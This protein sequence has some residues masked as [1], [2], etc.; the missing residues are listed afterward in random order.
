MTARMIAG[1][2]ASGLITVRNLP[3]ES[4]D[5]TLTLG[6]KTKIKAV[7]KVPLIDPLTSTP[8]QSGVIRPYQ[9]FICLVENDVIIDGGIVTGE[10]YSSTDRKVTWQG[11]GMLTYFGRRFVI[12][13]LSGGETPSDK[14]VTFEDL[15]LQTIMKRVVEQA[16][17]WGVNPPPI[18]FE[19]DVAGSSQKTYQGAD[20]R[21]VSKALQDLSELD[22]GPDFRFRPRIKSTDASKV[23]WVLE[24]GDPELSA[25]VDHVWDLSAIAPSASAIQ[26]DRGGDT[27]ATHGYVTGDNG[28]EKIAVDTTLTAAGYPM[29]EARESRSG[30]SVEATAQSYADAIVASGRFLTEAWRFTAR[31]DSTPKLED[32]RPGDYARLNV[33]GDP[34]IADGTYRVRVIQIKVPFGG[35]TFDVAC[36]PERV[37]A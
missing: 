11:G 3:V 21:T 5:V 10:S 28:L 32:V 6:E 34:Y 27:L 30:V 25:A 14:T 36:A 24:T 17:A 16:Q 1:D 20:Y 2:F 12:P 33:K 22:G 15:S 29:L 37:V 31:R 9:S 26:V 18:V 35:D 23:E 4:G 7:V 19:D 13:T 8:I